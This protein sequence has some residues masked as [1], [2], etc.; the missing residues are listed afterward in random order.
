MIR[1]ITQS[2]IHDVY[3]N[4]NVYSLGKVTTNAWWG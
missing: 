1:I 2:I 4:I 3:F